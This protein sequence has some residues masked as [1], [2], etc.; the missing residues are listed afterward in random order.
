MTDK[1]KDELATVAKEFSGLLTAINKGKPAPADIARLNTILDELPN[2]A[3]Q[4]GNL[5]NQVEI[6]ILD[7]GFQR[8]K[9]FILIVSRRMAL[10][11]DEMG[12]EKASMIE[13]GLIEHCVICWLRLYCCELR[14]ESL[15]KTNPSVMLGAYWESKLSAHQKRYLRAVET[16]A[17]VRRLMQKAPAPVMNTL[18][19]QNAPTATTELFQAFNRELSKEVSSNG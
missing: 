12:Y 16:L 8:D 7:N 9:G 13:R 4:L 14:Y 15:M 5:S 3:L 10:M 1:T 6:Q 19:M 17:R 11:R 2:L 18:I